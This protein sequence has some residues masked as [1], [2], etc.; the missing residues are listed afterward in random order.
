MVK[1]ILDSKDDITVVLVVI[2][3]PLKRKLYEFTCIERY[4][5]AWVLPP[6]D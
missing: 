5:A 1:N 3:N 6:V 4:N 2:E